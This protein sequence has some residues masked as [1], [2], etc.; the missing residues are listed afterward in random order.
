MGKPE[1]IHPW[2]NSAERDWVNDN[3]ESTPPR[4]H[5]LDNLSSEANLQ[6]NNQQVDLPRVM[7]S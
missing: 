1:I 6:L 3:E 4:I 7:N 5:D 2:L